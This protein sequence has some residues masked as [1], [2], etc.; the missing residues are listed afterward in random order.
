L[1]LLFI[2]V[3][4]SLYFV[5]KTRPHALDLYNSKELLNQCLILLYLL[6]HVVL[7]FTES[8]PPPKEDP[9][10]D[11]RKG[12]NGFLLAILATA[13]TS[14]LLVIVYSWLYGILR[15]CYS[16]TVQEEKQQFA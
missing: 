14:S 4:A 12:I 13:F 7:A 11:L 10:A 2:L 15:W 16:K 3:L 8:Y 1:I 9:H 5:S 6:C